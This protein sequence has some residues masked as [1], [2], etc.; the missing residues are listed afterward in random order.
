M[1]QIVTLY[2]MLVMTLMAFIC[3]C[4]DDMVDGVR[5]AVD[6]AHNA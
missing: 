5:R 2:L 4:I 6:I 1:I 3:D